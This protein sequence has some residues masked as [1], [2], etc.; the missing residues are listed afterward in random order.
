MRGNLGLSVLLTM[1]YT[2]QARPGPHASTHRIE[3]K[4]DFIVCV[5]VCVCVCE[6]L[7][8]S[9]SLS[10]SP[11]P[12]SVFWSKGRLTMDGKSQS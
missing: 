4:V 1:H 7:S 6:T 11:P 9:L 3:G 5:C 10:L 12:P 2:S 8:L